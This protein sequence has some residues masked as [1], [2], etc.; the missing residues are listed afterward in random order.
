MC[1]GIFYQPIHSAKDIGLGR[2]SSGISGIVRQDQ[3]VLR[4]KL[5]IPCRVHR[6]GELEFTRNAENLLMRNFRTFLA[7]FTQP[8]NSLAVPA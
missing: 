1:F 4:F 7:S 3:N 8:F 2:K 6:V 5:P